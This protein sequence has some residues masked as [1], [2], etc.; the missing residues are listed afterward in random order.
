[1]P[2]RAI[3]LAEPGLQ[4]FSFPLIFRNRL[5]ASWR[6]QRKPLGGISGKTRMGSCILLSFVLACSALSPA[7]PRKQH[8]QETLK[9][10]HI[11]L[12]AQDRSSIIR[13]IQDPDKSR[14]DESL[15]CLFHRFR[16]IDY[17]IQD[18]QFEQDAKE[19]RVYARITG[20]TI[21]ALT[22]EQALLEEDWH[23][24]EGRWALDPDSAF[25]TKLLG[26]CHPDSGKTLMRDPPENGS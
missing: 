15:G 4:R 24:R 23:Y 9:R 26:A 17:N 13:Y 21:N 1:M 14:W 10:F 11:A 5:A 8:F 22:T 20:R 18:I 2:F 25:F 19:A 6:A 7:G 3:P 12:I 16:L